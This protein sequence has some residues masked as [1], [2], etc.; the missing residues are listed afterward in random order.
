MAYPLYVV[1]LLLSNHFN[2][3]EIK[4]K[5]NEIHNPGLS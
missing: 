3:N 5:F 4:R 1:F 2:F